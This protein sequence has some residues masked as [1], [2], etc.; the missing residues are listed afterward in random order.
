M[1]MIPSTSTSVEFGSFCS[2]IV[3]YLSCLFKQEIIAHK[4]RNNHDYRVQNGHDHQRR[5]IISFFIQKMQGYSNT[6]NDQRI[7]SRKQ[8]ESFRKS[9]FPNHK[10]RALR[11]AAKTLNAEYL[12]IQAGNHIIFRSHL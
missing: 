12:F 10:H 11:A 3:Y 9:A 7:Y 4:V 5:S 1:E 6:E 2:F 8:L